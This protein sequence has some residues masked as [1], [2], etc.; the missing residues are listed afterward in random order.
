MIMGK[1]LND[2]TVNDEIENI[3]MEK[4]DQHERK[5]GI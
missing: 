4:I 1:K 2:I 3:G 5:L